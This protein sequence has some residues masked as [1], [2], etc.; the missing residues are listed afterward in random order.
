MVLPMRHVDGAFWT[1]LVKLRF[2]ALIGLLYFVLRRDT[3]FWRVLT[4]VGIA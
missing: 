1:L 3:L 2:Y 4:I